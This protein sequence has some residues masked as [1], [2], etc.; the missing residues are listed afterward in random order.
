MKSMSALDIHVCVKELQ[1]LVGGKVEKIY[2]YP[3]NEIRIK[4]YAKGR[5]D[6]IVEAGRRIHLT[7]FPKESPKFPSPFAMLLRKH[8][9]GKRIEK[10]WQHDF[11]R[12][13][14]IDFGDRKIVAELF[15]KGNIALVDENFNVIMDI[16][17]KRGRYNFPEKKPPFELTLDELKEL[18]S[19]EREIVKLLAVRCGLGGLF[20]EE[21]CLRSKIDKN[22]LGKDLSDD[23]FER[24]Y[25]AMMSIFEP[26]FRNDTKPHVVIKDGEYIDVLPIELEYYRNYEKKYFE[27]FNKALDEF[28]SKTIAEIE[29][30]ESEELKKLRKRLEIQLESKRKLEEEAEK[31]KAL[32]DF[33]YENYATIEKA[34]NAFK[35]AK[36][37][38]S[39][40]EFK[41][42]AKSL[43]F[44][45][46]VGKD[47]VV[48][49]LNGKEI[50][51]DLDKD[52]HGIAE[53]YYEKAKK[54]KEK[55]EGLLIAIEKTRKE[56]EEAERKERLKYAAPIRIVRKR[57]WFERFR[58][59]ITSD[60]F[61]AIGGRNAQM[62]EEIV[63][64]YLE[65]KDLF[66]HTQTPGA[67]AVVLKRGSEAPESSIVETA[68]FS[69]IY[70]SL[71]KQ[72]IH[73]GEVYYVTADQVKK[74]A[75]AGE[76]LPKGSFYVVGKRNYITVELKCAVGVDLSN[77]R[78]M[79]GPISAVSKHCDYYVILEIGD[80]D[81]NEL[82]VEIAKTLVERAKEDEKH[83]VKAIATPDEI[84]KFLPPGKSRIVEVHP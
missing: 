68:Q 29:E 53:S 50:R 23:E 83:V 20:A 52:I 27:S 5:K 63:S 64:K 46:D 10:I 22:K 6:L 82:S 40:E 11:D 2:H 54:A 69:A 34:L 9:E 56:I 3:P 37:K 36:E 28:Y 43:K 24:I 35:Q 12:V 51:L 72:G 81:V 7:I 48:I 75:K 26:V 15:A 57:E 67:P 1:E 13:V 41:N 32:G 74:S 30:G 77:L 49:V 42:R 33:I 55:L 25:R 18:C 84:S 78:V 21:I 47:Y 66:F 80:K 58:W 62:N 39:F 44:V 8:L 59:F 71:W 65:P 14:V 76:Y 38:M 16:H 31:F 70:S 19:E 4:I 17:G 61:L 79:G 60:G 73:S 45:K